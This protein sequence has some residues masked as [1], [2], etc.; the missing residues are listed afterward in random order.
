MNFLKK[1]KELKKIKFILGWHHGGV[2][3]RIDE[4]RELLILL[5]EEAPELLK[6]KPWIYQ[7]IESNDN[8]LVDLSQATVI[9]SCRFEP[10]EPTK[11]SNFSFPR[12]FPEQAPQEN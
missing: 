3:K 7:W 6:Q 8:F 11:V 5:Q 1:L 10:K 4:N 12:A 2:H 9:P